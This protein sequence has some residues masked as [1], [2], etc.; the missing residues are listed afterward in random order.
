MPHMVHQCCAL[1][2]SKYTSNKKAG[3][4]TVIG[5]SRVLLQFW[6]ESM[7]KLIVRTFQKL[8]L[9]NGD[10]G[11]TEIG[12]ERKRNLCLKYNDIAGYSWIIT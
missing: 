10:L 4:A 12:F 8:S 6:V 11:T 3:S 2:N 1:I 7:E 5:N 9:I